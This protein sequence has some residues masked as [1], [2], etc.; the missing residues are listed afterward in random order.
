MSRSSERLEV[1]ALTKA[2]TI[3]SCVG[4]TLAAFLEVGEVGERVG[5]VLPSLTSREILRLGSHGALSLPPV[6]D[7]GEDGVPGEDLGRRFGGAG[8]PGEE[9][10]GGMFGC[11][12]S[13][14]G[15]A[16]KFAIEVARS[17][18]PGS[19]ASTA[20]DTRAAS[21]PNRHGSR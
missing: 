3:S 21:A 11:E 17:W 4:H 13:D 7:E 14:D 15:A 5:E 12:M 19:T 8:E 18:K 10:G 9:G 2:T 16:A 20:R 6:G 1:V